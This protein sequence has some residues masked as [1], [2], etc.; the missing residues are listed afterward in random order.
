MNTIKKKK[1]YWFKTIT[2]CSLRIEYSI[3][4]LM[5]NVII[6]YQII[7]KVFKPREV[8]KIN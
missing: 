3:Y 1:F 4:E 7:S 8:S 6:H 2:I 5:V